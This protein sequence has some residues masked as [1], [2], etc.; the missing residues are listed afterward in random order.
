V[1]LAVAVV[2]VVQ[3]GPGDASPAEIDPVSSTTSA[4]ADGG[5]PSSTAPAPFDYRIGLLG[6]PSTDN[7]W[8]FY[9]SEET[10]WNAYVLGRTKPSLYR[11][12]PASNELV[13]DVAGVP[14]PSTAT[15]DG[16]SWVV[17]VPI[18][19]GRQ[20]SDGE[21][22]TA[23]D[24][25]FTFRTVRRLRLGG[26]W[27]ASYPA[28]LTDVVAVSDS[29]LRLEF[30]HKPGLGEWPYAVGLAPA[31]PEHV[32]SDPVSGVDRRPDLYAL[33]GAG[34]VSGGDLVIVE[35]EP[36][37]VVATVDQQRIDS[38]VDTVTFTVFGDESEAVEAINAG[39]IDTILSP[40]GL[41]SD[42]VDT[43]GGVPGVA[44][45][46]SP[47]NAVRYLGFNLDRFPMDNLAFREAVELLFDKE[48]SVGTIT[49]NASPAFS[50]LTPE[51][52]RWL[53]ES[54]L[55][56]IEGDGVGRLRQRLGTALEAL[57]EA[58]YTWSVDPSVKGGRIVPGEGLLVDDR[59][60]APLTILTPGDLYDPDRPRYAAELEEVIEGLGFD[61]RIVVTDFDTVVDLAFTP[62]EENGR[63]YDMY[64]LGW[65]LGNPVYPDFY[66]PL[67]TSE[68][69]ANS[70]GLD[71]KSFDRLW[72]RFIGANGE[73]EAR[74]LLWD[75][76]EVLS[77]QLPYLTLYHPVI[78][79]AYRSDSVVYGAG[80]VLGGIQGRGGG[81]GDVTPAG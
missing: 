62:D 76:E 80:E 41:S 55:D 35:A 10:V 36:S 78:A 46:V 17:E 48:G 25:E 8:T 11:A 38:V 13:A 24:F 23:H 33:S 18:A 51:N 79:E 30:D 71:S 27:I 54:R 68:G 63:Q 32:W 59:P 7:F 73:N 6:A 28:G 15:E 72:S 3:A 64:L 45:A 65:T 58:G 12:D 70:T 39:E 77:D 74:T 75:M 26:S 44:I 60:P 57:S 67:F 2:A 69:E 5:S 29:E 43:L 53:D 19:P 56:E 50:V 4:A 9:G 1:L 40:G 66:G 47:A 42:A 34:D 14:T 49:P 52:H 16:K 22:L 37:H 81:L 20:W 31:M 21:P 61:V